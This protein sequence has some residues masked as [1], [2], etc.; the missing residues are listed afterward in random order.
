MQVLK[1]FVGLSVVALGLALAAPVGAKTVTIVVGGVP[2]TLS[3]VQTSYASNPMQLQQQPWWGN[4]ALAFAITSQLQYQLGDLLGGPGTTPGIPSA[5]VAYG[6]AGP[7]VSIT[8]WDGAA[9]NCPV[10]CP[11]QADPFFYVISGTAAIPAT[12]AWATALLALLVGGAGL[13]AARALRPA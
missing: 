6:V 13:V 1:R 5:L 7:D 11:L 8:Y 2:Y 3:T 12:S 10:G 4:E 9:V